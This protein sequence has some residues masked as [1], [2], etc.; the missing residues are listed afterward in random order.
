[1]LS[2]IQRSAQ[3]GLLAR[4]FA[5]ISIRGKGVKRD[6]AVN[7]IVGRLGLMHGLPQKIGQLLAF[8]EIDSSDDL[9][10]S[11]TES[12]PEHSDPSEVALIEEQLGGRIDDLFRHF[13][14]EGISASIGK[15]HRAVLKDGR[16]VAVK[17][18]H[19]GVSEAVDFDL[20]A[21]GWLSAPVGDMRRN[22]DMASYRQEIGDSLREELDY[23]LEA[24]NIEFFNKRIRESGALMKVPE[25]VPELSGE[26]VLTT[27]WLYGEHLSEVNNWSKGARKSLANTLVHHFLSSSL[28]WGILH[29]DPHPGNYRFTHVDGIPTVGLLDFGCVKRLSKPFQ[30]GLRQ[31]I[32]MGLSD[33]CENEAVFEQ[34]IEMG[35]NA[36]ALSPMES[37]LGW[38]AKVFLEPFSFEG[39][40]D[41]GNWNM[42]ERLKTVLGDDRMSFRAS[43]PSELI[44]ILR[45]FQG[46]IQ[47]LKILDAPVDWRSAAKSVLSEVEEE[48]PSETDSNYKTQRKMML[49][50][51]LHVEIKQ[52][53]ITKVGL[54][55]GASATDNLASLVPVE[56]H[57]R[58]TEHSIDLAE[59]SHNAKAARYPI[60][61]LFSLDDGNKS[62]KVWL[63]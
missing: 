7:R 52:D 28:D 18:Q 41:V 34:F 36:E 49:S 60:G 24:E 37:K 2:S 51:T 53:G 62:V 54:T 14:L 40:F 10:L 6:R 1:M 35:F 13:E 23:R 45:S 17:I 21:L 15:V 30:I 9:F 27:T 33:N 42:G 48:A 11:L 20:K 59:I 46:L 56:L 31:L 3:L 29:A 47:Y 25:V 26:R 22:F 16:S 5:S 61:K 63:Q 44:F 43:G 12:E 19:P 57:E 32:Q 39:A 4:D 8:S 38:L 55:F 50:E 58:L